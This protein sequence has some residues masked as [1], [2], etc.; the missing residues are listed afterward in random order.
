MHELVHASWALDSW[1]ECPGYSHIHTAKRLWP[2]GTDNIQ[3]W[4]GRSDLN[5]SSHLYVELFTCD[6]IT[7]HVNVNRTWGKSVGCIAIRAVCLKLA[8][9]FTKMQRK[10]KMLS[11]LAA[12]NRDFFLSAHFFPVIVIVTIWPWKV[13]TWNN[14]MLIMA[15]SLLILSEIC[16]D[17]SGAVYLCWETETFCKWQTSCYTCFG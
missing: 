6:L 2:L 4:R 17:L 1:A 5:V 8:R 14:F 9:G 12:T 3:M 15:H 7:W 10:S 11:L 13:I 16:P